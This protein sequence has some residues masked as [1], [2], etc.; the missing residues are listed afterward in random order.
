MA[1]K[2]AEVSIRKRIEHGG[3][4]KEEKETAKMNR[5]CSERGF[6]EKGTWDRIRLRELV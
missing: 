3:G 4:R 1:W 6:A 2:C 5:G